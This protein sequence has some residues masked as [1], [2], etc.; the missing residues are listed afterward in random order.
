MPLKYSTITLNELIYIRIRLYKGDK[1]MINFL[2]L[3][4]TINFYD[5]KIMKFILDNNEFKNQKIFNCS[6]VNLKNKT[7]LFSNDEIFNIL[8]DFKNLNISYNIITSKSEYLGSFSIISSYK[9]IN[10]EKIELTFS[11]DFINTFNNQHFLSEININVFFSFSSF[12]SI[13]LYNF[14]LNKLSDFPYTKIEIDKL[15]EVLHLKNSYKRI[16]DF[17]K[18]VLQPSLNEINKISQTKF[19]YNKVKKSN[20]RNA[21]VTGFDFFSLTEAKFEKINNIL[22]FFD[23]VDN[24][25]TLFNQILFGLNSISYE[26][27]LEV[28]RKMLSEYENEF[29]GAKTT[30]ETYFIEKME[31]NISKYQNQY[32]LITNITKID[33]FNQYKSL[34]FENSYA[35]NNSFLF[36]WNDISSIYRNQ[37]FEY[38]DD[39]LKIQAQY[40]DDG[41]KSIKIFKKK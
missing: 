25:D 17:E 40:F 31:D 20:K 15:K 39:I 27:F 6:I 19:F 37:N 11:N 21:K 5:K 14:L 36:M 34:I 8:N 4:R 1:T 33:S 28:I 26:E 22:R 23:T 38:E 13:H 2:D 7:N 3:N 41:E 35:L 24:Y 32:T 12:S 10:N 9:V 18:Y 16:Y 30:F 29:Q